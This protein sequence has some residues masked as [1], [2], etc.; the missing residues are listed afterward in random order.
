MPAVPGGGGAVV[1]APLVIG[2]DPG[3]RNI[4]ATALVRQ[5]QK[6]R[7]VNTQYFG[8]SLRKERDQETTAARQVDAVED[9]LDELELPLGSVISVEAQMQ[10][11][12]GQRRSG[13]SNLD[14]E[15]SGEV[16]RA[17]WQLCRSHVA[18]VNWVEPRDRL[19]AIGVAPGLRS[20]AAKA[21]VM[22]RIP[23]IVSGWPAMPKGQLE[24]VADAGAIA[25]AGGR[26]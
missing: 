1:T 26:L 16:S 7:H 6:W 3:L 21:A 11:R 25:I 20:K 10:T 18:R 5:G 24:H 13:K 14:A 8:L 9:W 19:K 4:G 15:Y 17:L 2:I 22:H 23:L 12:L